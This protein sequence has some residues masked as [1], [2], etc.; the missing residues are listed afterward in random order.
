MPV[1]NGVRMIGISLVRVER[2]RDASE[3]E[4]WN[5]EAGEERAPRELHAKVGLSWQCESPV[6]QPAAAASICQ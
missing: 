3:H 4:R 1:D 6:K 2:R 5:Q